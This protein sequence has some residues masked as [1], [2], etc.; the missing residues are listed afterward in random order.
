[1]ARKF[2]CSRHVLDGFNQAVSTCLRGAKA[3]G[4]VQ[5]GHSDTAPVSTINADVATPIKSPCFALSFR[6]APAWLD[7]TYRFSFAGERLQHV[8][9]HELSASTCHTGNR[10]R[11]A[12][13]RHH[14]W[15]ETKAFAQACR[16]SKNARL[17]ARRRVGYSA[18]MLRRESVGIGPK[19]LVRYRESQRSPEANNNRNIRVIDLRCQVRIRRRVI[20][21]PYPLLAVLDV[22]VLDLHYGGVLALVERPAIDRISLAAL[23]L[24]QDRRPMRPVFHRVQSH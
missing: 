20:S 22:P 21:E 5:S 4:L 11:V 24:L 15:H 14:S 7:S 3:F 13:H 16:T 6:F 19:I 9:I 8:T 17:Q 2:H 12:S 23:L 10:D 1:M 18:P